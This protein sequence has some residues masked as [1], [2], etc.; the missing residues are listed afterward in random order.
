MTHPEV[1]FVLDAIKNNWGAVGTATVGSSTVGDSI[2]D[3]PL[4]RIDRDNSDF[5][6]R[7]L[8]SKTADLQDSNYVGATLAS[9]DTSPIGTEYDHDIEAVVGVRIEGLDAADYGHIDPEGADGVVWRDL[10][11]RLLRTILTERVCPDVDRQQTAYTDLRVANQAPQ[12]DD[13]DDY[14]RYDFDI[15]FNGYEELP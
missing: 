11:R 1:Q 8:S 5:L 7:S 9:R 4:E 3:V 2:G 13:Y 6:E 14:Y 15:L 10:I 12:S